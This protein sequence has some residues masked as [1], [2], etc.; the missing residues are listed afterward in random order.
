MLADSAFR[1]ARG[2]SPLAAELSFGLDVNGLPPVEVTLPDGRVLR[3]RG[4]IDRIDITPTG[5]VH[6]VDYKTGS[7]HQGYRDLLG[8]D[9]AGGGT[10]A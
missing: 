1:Q 9:P 4:R 2:T 8:G 10:K 7:Y 3:V 5:T 6:V